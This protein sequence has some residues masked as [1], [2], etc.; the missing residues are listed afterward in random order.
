MCL[1]HRKQSV[2]E[3]DA[4]PRVSRQRTPCKCGENRELRLVE[5][6][7]NR[8]KNVTPVVKESLKG[9]PGVSQAVSTKV[10]VCDALRSF[11]AMPVRTASGMRGRL[12]DRGYSCGDFSGLLGKALNNFQY[13]DEHPAKSRA[14]PPLR[15]LDG[16]R[17][18][19]K[20]SASAMV[21]SESVA[22]GA[23]SRRG[24]SIGSSCASTPNRDAE[25][26]GQRTW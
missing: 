9:A 18:V 25:N 4:L 11:Q 1:L 14:K 2:D 3:F 8:P 6:L 16:R 20:R 12:L 21:A 24:T 10:S 19:A 13:G 7:P 5:A 15:C 17:A 23:E 26:R 22:I